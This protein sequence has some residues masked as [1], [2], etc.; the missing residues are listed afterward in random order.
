MHGRCWPEQTAVEKSPCLDCALRARN[1]QG[2]FFFV[3]DEQILTKNLGRV[4]MNYVAGEGN[5]GNA[6]DFKCRRKWEKADFP[7]VGL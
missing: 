7:K 3:Q 6:V 1:R 5:R 4:L 2:F